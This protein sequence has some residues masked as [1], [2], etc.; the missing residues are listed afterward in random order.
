MRLWLD[1]TNKLVLGRVMYLVIMKLSFT[2]LFMYKT[3]QT[4]PKKMMSHFN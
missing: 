3:R 2:R 4:K 1:T